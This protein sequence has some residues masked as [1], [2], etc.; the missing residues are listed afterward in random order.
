MLSL[1][2]LFSKQN[3]V[4]AN[5]IQIRKKSGLK[6]IVSEPIPLSEKIDILLKE[7]IGHSDPPNSKDHFD[8]YFTV[9]GLILRPKFPTIPSAVL[10]RNFRR[11]SKTKKYLPEPVIDYIR[12]LASYNYF[13]PKKI[14][15]YLLS[16]K[17]DFRLVQAV[18]FYIPRFLAKRDIF[19]YD[20]GISYKITPGLYSDPLF[21]LSYIEAAGI[22]AD[23]KLENGQIEP[24]NRPLVK[25]LKL[26]FKNQVRLHPNVIYRLYYALPTYGKELFVQLLEDRGEKVPFL[27]EDAEF[28][29]VDNLK[30]LFDMVMSNRCKNWGY[31][32]FIKLVDIS[33]SE[34]NYKEGLERLAEIIM[35]THTQ[36]P[37]GLGKYFIDKT[38]ENRPEMAIPVAHRLE[39]LT[40]LNLVPYAV[41]QIMHSI[42][43]SPFTE[44]NA[45]L[46]NLLHKSLSKR[47]VIES[48][49]LKDYL[50]AKKIPKM[51]LP[52]NWHDNFISQCRYA[53]LGF[54]KYAF[55][56]FFEYFESYT[57]R[58]ALIKLENVKWKGSGLEKAWDSIAIK[59]E[60]HKNRSDIDS[61]SYKQERL[62]LTE[63]L[64]SFVDYLN[65]TNRTYFVIPFVQYIYEK[66]KLDV[67]FEAYEKA[68]MHLLEN[69]YKINSFGLIVLRKLMN[70]PHFKWGKEIRENH[71]RFELAFKKN[72]SLHE[73]GTILSNLKWSGKPNFELTKN[74]ELFRK[75]ALNFYVP[76]NSL[77]DYCREFQYQRAWG[78]IC[79]QPTI[80]QSGYEY[81]MKE[82]A[83]QGKIGFSYALHNSIVASKH[84]NDI[85]D[86]EF[87]KLKVEPN[88]KCL[89]D[90]A[91]GAYSSK[92]LKVNKMNV[93]GL[94]I[95]LDEAVQE[96]LKIEKGKW[97]QLVRH[98]S[99]CLKKE[100]EH[101]N[102]RKWLSV[103][104]KTE[105]VDTAEEIFEAPMQKETDIMEFE[106]VKA[107]VELHLVWEKTM[108]SRYDL[109]S[110]TFKLTAPCFTL[111]RF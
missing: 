49:R 22:H 101:W 36:I 76:F 4:F 28:N 62:Y 42:Y 15:K 91:I 61:D 5:S 60:A 8:P 72:I 27:K 18:Q 67:S 48:Q 20:D 63:L 45:I 17:Q 100:K 10:S 87:A 77:E 95:L 97:D 108:E 3:Y 19:E 16:F 26:L 89:F 82:F 12:E 110:S 98:V 37:I 58:E 90:A 59:L 81:L 1:K 32:A 29:N 54:T 9:D 51:E 44:K 23:K 57:D 80:H 83:S 86:N 94:E 73:F 35:R 104:E 47:T 31:G 21:V 66:F 70:V 14:Q 79:T 2:V 102:Y 68:T 105:T 24:Y 109:N 64:Y 111:M 75:H 106:E 43:Q 41:N 88:F 56:P 96:G 78:L 6:N 92:W 25:T 52:E 74:E 69:S 13:N 85:K 71:P 99:G 7:W 11:K 107:N 50:N 39:F 46:V 40:G 30:S 33:T 103:V 55:E 34:N 93:V 53:S 84:T 65:S 38:I